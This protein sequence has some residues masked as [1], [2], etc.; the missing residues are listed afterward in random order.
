MDMLQKYL[1]KARGSQMKK[2]ENEIGIEY[3]V[4]TS[5]YAC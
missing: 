4:M 5:V 1:K 3:R 2:F